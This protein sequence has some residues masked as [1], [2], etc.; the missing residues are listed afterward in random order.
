MAAP[1]EKSL[2]VSLAEPLLSFEKGS[3]GSESVT[4]PVTPLGRKTLSRKASFTSGHGEEEEGIALL[5]WSR[6]SIRFGEKVAIDR[7][8]G[9]VK[10]GEFLALMG[11]SGAGKTTLLDLL[12]GRLHPI[13]LGVRA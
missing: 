8:S 4:A 12:T 2:S 6:L 1:L 13:Q 9:A 11:P 5:E 10:R 7:A 3:Y